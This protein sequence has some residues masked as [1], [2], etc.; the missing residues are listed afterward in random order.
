NAGNQQGC[1]WF[2][3]AIDFSMPFTHTMEMQFGN[4]DAGADG[5][6]LV[7]QSN[8][9]N[10]CGVSGEGIGAQGIPNSLI[11][12]FDTYQNGSQNDPFQ[13]H[14]SVNINGDM[15]HANS[16]AGPTVVGG[17][18]IEDGNT[19]TVDFSWDPA[20]MSYQV[21]LDGTL[22]L[23]GMFDIV[24]NVF[25]GS[26]MAFWGYTSSTG[27]ASNLQIVCPGFES[28]PH[29][30]LDS[31]TVTICE[32]DSHVAGGAAQT[33]SGFY[34]DDFI[35]INGCDSILIT[36]LIVE[37]TSSY[38][39]V[40]IICEGDIFSLN[41]TDYNIEGMYE[42]NVMAANLCDSTINIDL[43]VLDPIVDADVN[44]V[45]TCDQVEVQLEGIVIQSEDNISF[46]WVGP[47][48][49]MSNEQNTW[50]D[51]PGQY[52]FRI[53]AS[54]QNIDCFSNEV[55]V[56]V[57]RD[58][59]F[60]FDASIIEQNCDS[61]R[62]DIMLE[63]GF[64]VQVAGPNGFMTDELEFSVFEEGDYL[65]QTSSGSGCDDEITLN[66]TFDMTPTAEIIGDSTIDC[67][68]GSVTLTASS[69]STDAV[70]EWTDPNGQ[71]SSGSSFMAGT[72]GW[73]ILQ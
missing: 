30:I 65:I 6:C 10:E 62:I 73:H 15:N 46:E 2:P 25:G 24:N 39:T 58:L 35:T 45:L 32:G 21:F 37:P 43:I 70:F 51:E 54:D 8:S 27:G 20:T 5:I 42:Q 33:T 7:Y 61:A 68:N 47:N 4:N 50:V 55:M 18:D 23:N 60:I 9:S 1:V 3:E 31:V 28:F 29:G 53:V 12:E 66:V 14:A 41:G 59:D 22:I 64:T 38:D 56:E 11:V 34:Q 26:T 36:E 71:I 72:P 57:E 44:G 69:A 17:G 52:T 63:N 49:F 48:G 67:S 19:Y 40:A 16:I 13:D